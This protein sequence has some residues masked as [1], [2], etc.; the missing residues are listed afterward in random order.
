V[1]ETKYGKIIKATPVTSGTTV[2]CRFPYTKKASPIEPKSRPQRRVEVF[3]ATS[4]RLTSRLSGRAEAFDTRHQR[5]IAQCA[6]GASLLGVTGRSKRWLD[7]V[8]PQLLEMLDGREGIIKVVEQTL[9]VLIPRGASKP[10]RVIFKCPPPY[11]Q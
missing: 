1:L 11:E 10:D 7:A 6:H 2:F 3:I 9:P 8:T 4:E 5:K